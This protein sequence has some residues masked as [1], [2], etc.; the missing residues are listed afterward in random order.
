[1]ETIKTQDFIVRINNLWLK[2][3]FLLTSGDYE[4]NKYNTMTVAWGYFGIMWNKPCATVFVRPT[5]YTFEF[6]NRYDT[7]TL[8]AFNKTFKNDLSL[9]GTISGRDGDKIP[10]TG[11]TITSSEKIAAPTFKEA[12]LTIECRKIYQDDIK[13]EKFL[14]KSIEKEYPKKDYHRMYFGEIIEITGDEKF[15]FNM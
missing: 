8:S 5:R 4:N 15:R 3:W 14:D 11:L 6:I 1:M 12:E 10:K 9:L 7:F 2:Q 13:P